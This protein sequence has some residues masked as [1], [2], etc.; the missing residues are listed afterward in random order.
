MLALSR[1]PIGGRTAVAFADRLGAAY[2]RL[3]V[4]DF[5]HPSPPEEAGHRCRLLDAGLARHS[6]A[7][8]IEGL[9]AL[10]YRADLNPGIG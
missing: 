3:L 1:K 10:V 7:P 5:P 4:R 6:D 9:P 2:G 8:P